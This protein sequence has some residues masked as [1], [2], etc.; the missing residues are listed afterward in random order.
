[1]LTVHSLSGCGLIGFY[2]LALLLDLQTEKEVQ[3]SPDGSDRG[4]L[5]QHHEA[6]GHRGAQDIRSQL[7]LEPESQEAPEVQPHRGEGAIPSRLNATRTSRQKAMAAPA[8]MTTAPA[9]ST[10]RT[11]T[12]M[13]SR[14]SCSPKP[15]AKIMIH[16]S[17]AG[18]L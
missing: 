3:R 18:A 11:A 16:R 1:M 5:G 8:K 6:R 10:M 7:E 12:S 17:V 2:Q 15:V 13:T 9:A 4:Q 14:R